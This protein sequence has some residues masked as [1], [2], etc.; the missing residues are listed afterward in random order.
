MST[1]TA[2]LRAH[3]LT[4]LQMVDNDQVQDMYQREMDLDGYFESE[5]DDDE[6]ATAAA[7]V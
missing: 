5:G 3:A 7:K 6:S 4:L 1:D 2:E